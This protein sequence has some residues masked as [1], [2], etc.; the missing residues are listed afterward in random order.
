M[1]IGI[2]G[3]LEIVTK[4]EALLKVEFKEIIYERIIYN[5]YTETPNLI[6]IVQDKLDAILFAGYIPYEL[7]KSS[8]VPII[9]WESVPRHG[10][11]IL[12]ALLEAKLAGYNIFNLSLDS[13]SYYYLYEAYEEIGITTEK[14]NLYLAEDKP[15]DEHYLDYIYLFHKENFE[16]KKVSCCFTG[17]LSIYNKLC[18]DN[19]PCL[20]VTPTR[21]IIRESI[22]RLQ[23]KHMLQISSQS[24]IVSICISIDSP[25]EYSILTDNEYRYSLS[26]IKVLEQIYMFAEKIQAAVIDLNQGYY[27]LFCTK[28]ILEVETG[29]Y[30]HIDLLD[31]ICSNTMS[32]ISMGI[33]YGNTAKEAKNNAIYGASTASKHGGNRAYLIY[34]KKKLLGPVIG[35]TYKANKNNNNKIDGKLH[36]ISEKAGI[37]I[38]SVFKLYN[39]IEEQKKDC[40]TPKELAELYNITTRSMN[41]IIEKLE[42][43]GLCK[44]IGKKSSTKVGRPSR[45]IKLLI[46]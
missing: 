35:T 31:S 28:K 13:Y 39:I 25:N 18:N 42:S 26:K 16:Y 40:F 45:I 24:Q 22:A 41:R 46:K 17:I 27:I 23:L 43:N 21:N 19:I 33:G 32:T 29:N 44:I 5:L 36:E 10:G 3:P 20:C 11:C 34:E 9:P 6:R 2:V 14:L 15:L 8:T 30:Q 7:A 1:K 4:I 12:R 37:S 38:D